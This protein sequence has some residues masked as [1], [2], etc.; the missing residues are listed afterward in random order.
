LRTTADTVERLAA[1]LQM[2][3]EQ[4]GKAHQMRW[5]SEGDIPR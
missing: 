1:A 2:I 4:S 3:L 5:W